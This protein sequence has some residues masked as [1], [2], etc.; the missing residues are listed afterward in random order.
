[1][2]TKDK[3]YSYFI[4][5]LNNQITIR[6]NGKIAPLVT[7]TGLSESYLRNLA[8]GVKTAGYKAQMKI[9]EAFGMDL[10]DFLNLGQQIKTGTV[11]AP[12]TE[13]AYL[14]KVKAR[15]AAG[16]G[17]FET[18]DEQQDLFAFRLDWLRHKGNPNNL[19]L[20]DVVGDSM[21]PYIMNGDTIMVDK[22]NTDL[23]PDKVY[24]VR[25]E[26]LIYLKYIDR[27][28]GTFIL[29]SHNKDYDPIYIDTQFLNENSL[30]ILGRVIW[31]AHD[32]IGG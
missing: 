11:L 30:A 28:P 3:S 21:A 10:A 19:V 22:S 18:S 9:A 17:S 20:M 14:K 31:W 2:E 23:L 29:R 1:M 25:V 26:D 6:Y 5:A 4:T 12:N 15:P 7:A 32:E 8:T 13:F 24:V 27:I 16:N